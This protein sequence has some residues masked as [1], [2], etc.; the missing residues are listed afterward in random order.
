MTRAE[1]N[2]RAIIIKA[3]FA[4]RTKIGRGKIPPSA[5]LACTQ[6]MESNA[7]D[8]QSLASDLLRGMRQTI[9][10]FHAERLSGQ[11]ALSDLRNRIMQFKG[12]AATFHYP[13]L[14]DIAQIVL[15]LIENIEELDAPALEIITAFEDTATKL[16]HRQIRGKS[17]TRS[18]KIPAEFRKAC[19]RYW[20]KRQKA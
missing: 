18:A 5:I 15:D 19:E 16:L 10:K 2:H 11:E 7:F 13:L 9:E 8:F 3:N 1:S 12:N 17:D 6:L 4:L 20:S 14:T